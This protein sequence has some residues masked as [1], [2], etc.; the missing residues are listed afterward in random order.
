VVS[1]EGRCVMLGY[2]CKEGVP[3]VGCGCGSVL[4]CARS[5]EGLGLF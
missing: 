5:A 4:W 2:C 1:E 3:F